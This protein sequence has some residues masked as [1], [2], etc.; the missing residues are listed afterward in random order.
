MMAIVITTIFKILGRAGVQGELQ[1]AE[2][3]PSLQI[4]E[5]GGNAVLLFVLLLSI[6]SH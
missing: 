6:L 3:G 1:P 2:T 5:A 4:P